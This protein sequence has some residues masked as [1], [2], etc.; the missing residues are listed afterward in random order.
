MFG[1]LGRIGCL[2][3]ILVGGIAAWFT[4]DQ[5]LHRVGFDSAASTR[6]ADAAGVD[7][8]PISNAAAER[9]STAVGSLSEQRGYVA[10]SGAEASSWIVSRFTERIPPGAEAVEA[11]VVGDRLELRAEVPLGD[12]GSVE[13]L[14]PLREFVGASERIRVSGRLEMVSPGLAQFRVE[15][16][17]VRNWSVPPA[18][19]PV[20][21]REVWRGDR[22]E[23]LAPDALGIDVPDD[24]GQVRVEGGQVII[25]RTV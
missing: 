7:F 25:Y 20:L 19:V 9:G 6:S 18:V 21:L 8:Q 10:L 12:L 2:V 11:A 16:M 13:G 1:C 17:R 5:W 24:V 23:G 15:R 22:P 4:R 14:G 3:L